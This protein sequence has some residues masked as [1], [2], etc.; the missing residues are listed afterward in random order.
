MFTTEDLEVNGVP[1]LGVRLSEYP[2]VMFVLGRVSLEEVDGQ[3]KLSYNY[4]VVEGKSPG[5]QFEK[6]VGDF[7]VEYCLTNENKVFL[8][9]V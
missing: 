4:D 8:G 6:S 5:K 9:G 7:I 1:R 3:A 2:D